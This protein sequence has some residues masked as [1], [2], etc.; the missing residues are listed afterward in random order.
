MW[1]VGRGWLVCRGL[2]AGGGTQSPVITWESKVLRSKVFPP[3]P[4]SPASTNAVQICTNLSQP[5]L[6]SSQVSKNLWL[7]RALQ[8]PSCPPI[9]QS[10]NPSSSLAPGSHPS[11]QSWPLPATFKC[12]PGLLLPDSAPTETT[13]LQLWWELPWPRSFS[14]PWVLGSQTEWH[15]TAVSLDL[16]NA[17]WTRVQT[18]L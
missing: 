15:E 8:G 6:W 16:P 12:F 14:L 17:T 18:R 1:V 11:E 7:S 5:L 10:C 13:L 2:R 3:P 9:P 4:A